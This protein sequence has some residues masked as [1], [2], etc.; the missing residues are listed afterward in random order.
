MTVV[1][2]KLQQS[3]LLTK[4]QPL[5]S[6]YSSDKLINVPADFS[7][8]YFS[9]FHLNVTNRE[10]NVENRKDL[11]VSQTNP[12]GVIV[13]TETWLVDKKEY[14]SLFLILNCSLISQIK[15]YS[16]RGSGVVFIHKFLNYKIIYHLRKEMMLLKLYWIIRKK[17]KEKK[18]CYLRYILV[19]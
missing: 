5:D 6:P 10:K 3:L 15:K 8:D 17:S 12:C 16:H 19:T 13:L 1:H 18:L 9:I 4:F 14:N 7:K 2:E 11:I